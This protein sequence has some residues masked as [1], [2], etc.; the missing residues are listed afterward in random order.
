MW[1]LAHTSCRHRPPIAEDTP[2]CGVTTATNPCKE[3]VTPRDLR[4]MFE[5]D[6]DGVSG[7]YITHDAIAVGIALLRRK[8]GQSR[9]LLADYFH[10][11]PYYLM[12]WDDTTRPDV[13]AE[14]TSRARMLRM[15][16]GATF[17]RDWPSANWL[18]LLKQGYDRVLLPYNLNSNH[19]IVLEVVFSS[20]DGRYI[21]VWDGMRTWGTGRVAP[22]TR[23]PQEI[24]TLCDIFFGGDEVEVRLWEQGDPLQEEG[25]GCG[26]FAFLVI[27]FLA[28]G[29]R[30]TGWTHQDEAVARSF[31]WGG[32]L[33][34]ELYPLPELKLA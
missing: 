30:P 21:K 23:R 18:R 14:E 2:L 9:T 22:G 27:C 15:M 5:A 1:W 32:I 16:W 12:D 3:Y 28:L 26:P 7:Q 4:A 25:N 8:V 29:K 19:F 10:F 33:Q 6:E 34:G 13:K 24:I 20:L 17:P 31:L 11:T